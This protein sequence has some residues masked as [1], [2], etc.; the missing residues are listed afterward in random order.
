[1]SYSTWQ[2]SNL[3]V[4]PAAVKPCENVSIHVTVHN[5]GTLDG[6]E[7]VQLYVEW[8]GVGESPTPD[9]QLADF[10]R[11]KPP[12]TTNTTT[13]IPSCLQEYLKGLEFTI[14]I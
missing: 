3:S 11:V 9:I 10:E 1:M 14:R 4:T 7:V 2:Y 8:A 5:T 6:G 13:Q 12:P